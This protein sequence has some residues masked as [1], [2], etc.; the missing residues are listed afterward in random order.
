M[1][2][3]KKLTAWHR[4]QLG[5][6]ESPAGSNRTRY[7]AL[8]GVNGVAWC[9]QYIWAG[10][11]ECG[12]APLFYGGG[13]VASCTALMKWAKSVGHW[14]TGGY[15]EGD[16]I[17]YDFSG[18]AATAEHV[19]YCTGTENGAVIAIEGNTSLS[20]EG[21]Q[22]NGGTVAEKK[23]P[24]S[25]VLGAFRPEYREGKMTQAE[26]RAMMDKYLKELAAEEPAA[27]SA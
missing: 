23:R 11:Y 18:T 17:L 3:I 9:C 2:D 14:V 20:A 7:G 26:F 4:A 27:W 1:S 22:T 21:S 8:Y 12:L 13:K 16:I 5:T 15:R 19:G 6:A 24:L 10:F 25:K